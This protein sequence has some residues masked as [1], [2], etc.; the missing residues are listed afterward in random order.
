MYLMFE[1]KKPLNPEKSIDMQGEKCAVPARANEW[2]R[3]EEKL[4]RRTKRAGI[5]TTQVMRKKNQAEK[6]IVM[7]SQ[8]DFC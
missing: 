6:S 1:P 8:C 5:L 7:K 4:S 3:S 2:R